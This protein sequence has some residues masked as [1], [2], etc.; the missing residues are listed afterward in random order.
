MLHT[1]LRLNTIIRRTSGRSQGT[2]EQSNALSD[3]GWHWAGKHSGSSTHVSLRSAASL[4]PH[5]EHV[6]VA[7]DLTSIRHAWMA[8]SFILPLFNVEIFIIRVLIPETRLAVQGDAA[9]LQEWVRD[10]RLEKGGTL[11]Q[12]E[13]VQ[14][15]LACW[16]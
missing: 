11:Q 7:N 2:S 16:D 3:I 6:Q 4:V 10:E 8:S 1:H 13:G 12:H 9:W 5:N 14:L 15:R